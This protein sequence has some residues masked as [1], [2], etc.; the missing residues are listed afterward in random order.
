MKRVTQ[1]ELDFYDGLAQRL[2]RLLGDPAYTLTQSS[3]ASRIGWH[4]ASLCNFLNRIDKTIPAHFIPRIAQTLH[5]S[6]DELMGGANVHTRERTSWDPR[7][8]DAEVLIDQ[9]HAWRDRNLPSI[10]LHAHL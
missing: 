6:V 8:D 7:A 9:L 5:H 3:L 2:N 4:R 10:R 1:D